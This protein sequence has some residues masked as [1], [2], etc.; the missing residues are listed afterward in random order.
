LP[1]LTHNPDFLPSCAD[2]YANGGYGDDGDGG[3]GGGCDDCYH[4]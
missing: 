3:V 4:M 1:L 2:D